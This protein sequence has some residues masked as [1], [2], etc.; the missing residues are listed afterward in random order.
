MSYG[1]A[2]IKDISYVAR[3]IETDKRVDPFMTGLN[4]SQYKGR[5]N[6]AGKGFLT[7]CRYQENMQFI[8]L[9]IFL[10]V[11]VIRVVFFLVYNPKKAKS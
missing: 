4:P 6:C 11:I 8:Q 3:T 5:D 1:F 7:S 2:N 10:V 9:F